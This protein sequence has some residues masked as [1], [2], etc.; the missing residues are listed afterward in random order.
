MGFRI[1]DWHPL[2]PQGQ[3]RMGSHRLVIIHT[4]VGSLLGTDS[5][6]KQQ[7]YGGVESHF[8]TGRN[9][10]IIQW[11]DTDYIAEANLAANGYAISIENADKG[12][13]FPN[14]DGSN[15]PLFSPEQIEANAKICALAHQHYGIPLDIIHSSAPGVRGI[16]YHR[17]GIEGYG[18]RPGYDKWSSARGKVCPG[19]ARVAQIPTIIER[20]RQIVGGKVSA[21]IVE[22]PYVNPEEQMADVILPVDER[23]KG[24]R[25][26]HAESGRKGAIQFPKGQAW[27]C[28]G[29]T[30]GW[31]EFDIF[32]QDG[33]GGLLGR[34]TFKLENNHSNGLNAPQDVRMVTLE[35][36]C[37]K[38]PTATDPGTVPSC[39]V[40]H[41]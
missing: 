1:G 26:I 22:P 18:W 40:F 37:E 6:F 24:R 21:P 23:G 10:R 33:F 19:N 12:E 13:G 36:T 4:M 35:Y 32:F 7:G 30:W 41:Q 25:T 5:Y 20:A 14:W 17:A 34:E 8:G 28:V 15:V 16:S 2:G 29:S 9:G 27:V 3:G 31:T 38:P 39:G 11:Q